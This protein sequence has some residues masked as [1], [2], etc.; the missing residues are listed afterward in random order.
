MTKPL[1]TVPVHAIDP[2]PDA[3]QWLVRDLWTTAAVGVIGGSPK[4]GKS[5][6]GL[7]L[8]GLGRVR[9]SGPSGAS[10]WRP[11][12]P[13]WSISPRMP[14]R[15][16]ATASPHLCRHR[17]LDLSRLD[18]A[19]RPR[20]TGLRLDTERDRLA[21]DHTV[22]RIRPALLLLDPLV[23]LHSLDENS[24]SDIS[25]L[26]GFLRARQPAP[27]TRGRPR[28]PHGQAFAAQSRPVP[29]W[30]LRSACLDRFRLLPRA[31]GR[32]PPPTHRRAP[33]RSRSRS[34]SCCASQA[35]RRPAPLA[36]R[37]RCR[38]TAAPA[39]RGRARR[40]P[41]RRPT[42]SP[43]PHSANACAS[44]TLVSVSPSKLSNSAASVRGPNGWHLP[45]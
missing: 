28:P 41:H 27:S 24:A 26:L 37:R 5:W 38:R 29:A 16:S 6:L 32:R 25:S 43:G 3:P 30:L 13:P 31:A 34:R 45:A 19:R 22:Q 42:R 17:G 15:A 21:L 39:H 1:P 23:R 4:V 44:T 2:Q 35:M 11:P 12:D 9:H 20:P 14:C 10:R 7:D 36:D 18:L 40:S 33:R 8:A